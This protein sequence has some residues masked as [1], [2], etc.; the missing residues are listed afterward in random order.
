MLAMTKRTRHQISDSFVANIK[1]KNNTKTTLCYQTEHIQ[2]Q[3]NTKT[4]L[5][6]QVIQSQLRMQKITPKHYHNTKNHLSS[7][8]HKSCKK[9]N[10][11]FGDPPQNTKTPQSLNHLHAISVRQHSTVKQCDLF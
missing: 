5:H 4:L 9:E 10:N 7:K 2:N 6:L 3:Q 11:W 1:H 8:H